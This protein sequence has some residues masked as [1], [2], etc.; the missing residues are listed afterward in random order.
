ML[1]IGFGV[2]SL[3]GASKGYAILEITNVN[4]YWKC[5]MF[6]NFDFYFVCVFQLL[7]KVRPIGTNFWTKNFPFCQGGQKSP[8]PCFAPPP[9]AFADAISLSLS[10]S[11]SLSNGAFGRAR[12]RQARTGPV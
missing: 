6:Q 12:V 9:K 3:L 11:L 7:T 10:L 8:T 5:Y 1:A 2:G 4:F